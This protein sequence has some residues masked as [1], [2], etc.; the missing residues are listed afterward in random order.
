LPEA[1]PPHLGAL[2]LVG[3]GFVALF[4]LKTSLALRP[5]GPLARA[6]YPRLFAGLYLDELFTRL[7]FRLWPPRLPARKTPTPLSNPK[8]LEA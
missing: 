2:A 8:P 3:L 1:A 7:T 4:G 6:L 5:E